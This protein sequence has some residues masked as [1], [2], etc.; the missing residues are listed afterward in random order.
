MARTK[1]TP[2]CFRLYSLKDWTDYLSGKKSDILAVSVAYATD[3]RGA[4]ESFR[5]GKHTGRYVMVW[6]DGNDYMELSL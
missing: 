6:N 1:T 5:H 3:R 2:K 4:A